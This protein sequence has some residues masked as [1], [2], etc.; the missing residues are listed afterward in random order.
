MT[1]QYISF[2]PNYLNFATFS[3]DSVLLSVDYV[4][5][6]CNIYS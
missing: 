4:D 6:T 1:L 5:E 3:K 2:V